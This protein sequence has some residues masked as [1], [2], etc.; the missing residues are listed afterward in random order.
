MTSN[1]DFQKD[2]KKP[3]TKT[4]KTQD[5]ITKNLRSLL[6]TA[7]L[8]HIHNQQLQLLPHTSKRVKLSL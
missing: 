2:E 5:A 7:S 3:Q 8:P 6:P 1:P 4:L